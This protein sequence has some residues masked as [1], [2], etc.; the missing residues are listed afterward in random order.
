M[1]A[2]GE[3]PCKLFEVVCHHGDAAKV[4]VH[5]GVGFL[6][7]EPHEALSVL[8]P[9]ARPSGVCFSLGEAAA[10][11]GEGAEVVDVGEHGGDHVEDLRFE[12]IEGV[13]D[14]GIGGEDVLGFFKPPVEGDVVRV[15]APDEVGHV[16]ESHVFHSGYPL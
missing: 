4:Q 2:I 15:G 1:A 10:E 6:L 13:E 5:D 8:L 7:V 14:D 9:Q 16:L 12:L 3:P 11:G